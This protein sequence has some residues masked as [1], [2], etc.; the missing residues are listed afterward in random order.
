MKKIENFRKS[1]IINSSASLILATIFGALVFYNSY[2]IEL[3]KKNIKKIKT[4]TAQLR[5]QTSELEKKIEDAKKYKEIW[6][7]LDENKK[8]TQIIKIDEI[9]AILKE[10]SE[11]YNIRKTNI[12]VILPIEINEG[13]FR[14]KTLKTLYSTG[15]LS[16]EALDDAKCLLFIKNFFNKFPGYVIINSF[17]MKKASS[18][19]GQD[20]IQISSGK[21]ISAIKANVSFSWYSYR[22]KL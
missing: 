18:Y 6:I 22:D 15:T 2:S 19:S 1:I 5:I 21:E 14:A 17:E 4:S 13:V 11:K 20:L 12:Q 10:T 3:N 16:F 8:T 9:N 7:Q